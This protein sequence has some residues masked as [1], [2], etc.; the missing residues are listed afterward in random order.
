[1][2]RATSNPIEMRSRPEPQE[3]FLHVLIENVIE[4][5]PCIRPWFLHV[6]LRKEHKYACLD[7]V[8]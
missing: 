6:L 4:N 5:T 2:T 7:V 8:A 3:I 1:M